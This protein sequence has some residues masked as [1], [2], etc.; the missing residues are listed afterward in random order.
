MKYYFSEYAVNCHI[1]QDGLGYVTVTGSP[2][3]QWFNSNHLLGYMTN[4]WYQKEESRGSL[5]PTGRNSPSWHM[6]PLS[7]REGKVAIH[8]NVLKVSASK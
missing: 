1:T 5:K 7:S 4:E 6:L 8:L 3:D 2:K